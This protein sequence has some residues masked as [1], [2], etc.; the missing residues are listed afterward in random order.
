MKAVSK[1]SVFRVDFERKSSEAANKIAR[2]MLRE[3]R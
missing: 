2:A 1:I 3:K